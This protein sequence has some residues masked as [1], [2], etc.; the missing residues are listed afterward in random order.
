MAFNLLPL[1]QLSV[2][3]IQMIAAQR[4]RNGFHAHYTGGFDASKKEFGFIT[5]GYLWHAT[6]ITVVF[7]Y[8]APSGLKGGPQATY[9][10]ELGQYD[11]HFQSHVA[12]NFKGDKEA[13]V[14]YY[15]N[16]R[17]QSRYDLVRRD[18]N[19]FH[20]VQYEVKNNDLQVTVD[21]ESLIPAGGITN[22][23]DFTVFYT[24]S[25]L[26]YAPFVLFESHFTM[27]DVASIIQIPAWYNKGQEYYFPHTNVHIT[28]GGYALWNGTWTPGTKLQAINKSSRMA[29]EVDVPP[30][31][32]VVALVKFYRTGVTF[33][34]AR[35][36]SKTP[37]M[38]RRYYSVPLADLYI[39]PNPLTLVEFRA[40]TGE[41]D[42]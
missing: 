25:H 19:G 32:K 2:K 42:Y 39:R 29:S 33:A 35:D 24:T 14:E 34:D 10:I 23:V 6:S 3:Q 12:L 31:G 22:V 28:V 27:D 37:D 8:P 7:K 40:V 36:A 9:S 26:D 5:P 13:Y 16:N 38:S 15:L 4:P 18:M 17:H 30:S 20:A 1:D 41:I 11:K 21:G